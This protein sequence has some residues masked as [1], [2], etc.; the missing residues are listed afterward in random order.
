MITSRMNASAIIAI[1]TFSIVLFQNAKAIL[2]KEPV[3]GCFRTVFL[4]N[5]D[6]TDTFKPTPKSN[7]CQGT[8]NTIITNDK[9][10]LVAKPSGEIP[11]CAPNGAKFCCVFL[12]PIPISQE[13]AFPAIGYFDLGTPLG[14]RKWRAAKV[15][16][17]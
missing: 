16:C 14:K 8:I 10:Y 13:K 2:G 1:L 11:G 7:N 5:A 17:Q 4:A 12:E 6:G 15:H 3:S 9:R